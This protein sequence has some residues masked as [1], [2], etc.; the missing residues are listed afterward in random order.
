[1]NAFE[2]PYSEDVLDRISQG[3]YPHIFDTC[4]HEML[5]DLQEARGTSQ[6]ILKI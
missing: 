5:P 2:G 6:C 4:A 3:Q 1:M